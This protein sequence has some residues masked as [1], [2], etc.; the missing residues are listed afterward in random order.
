MFDTVLGIADNAQKSI[1]ERLLD[2]K[3]IWHE[4]KNGNRQ[5]FA[6]IYKKYYYIL[7]NYGFHLVPDKE[8]VRDCLQDLFFYLWENKERIVEPNSIKSYLFTAFKRKL[9]DAAQNSRRFSSSYQDTDFDIILSIEQESVI[10]QTKSESLRKLQTAIDKLTKRQRE[11]IFLRYFE[12]LD[13]HEIASIME[14]NINSLYVLMSRA[15]E[16]LRQSYSIT[17]IYFGL[18]FLKQLFWPFMLSF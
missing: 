6:A 2:E 8:L 5:A 14:C 9:I 18:T 17:V 3:L 16:A 13:Y 11:A 10:E 12:N 4:Y 15:M 1:E 7:Y